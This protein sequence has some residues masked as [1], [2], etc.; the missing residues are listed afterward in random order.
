[1]AICGDSDSGSGPNRFRVSGG[2]VNFTFAAGQ[3]SV[4]TNQWLGSTPSTGGSA[5]G[6]V[7]RTVSYTGNM[8]QGMT[9]T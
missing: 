8:G 9:V 6:F 7:Y 1:M 4:S 3:S 2:G 5:R